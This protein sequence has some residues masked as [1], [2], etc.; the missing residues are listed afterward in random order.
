M[1]LITVTMLYNYY[2]SL[3]LKFFITPNR[4]SVTIK[5]KLYTWPPPATSNL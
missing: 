1:I 2:Q 5:Q 3:L 4:N